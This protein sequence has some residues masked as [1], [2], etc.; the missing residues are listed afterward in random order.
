MRELWD[1]DGGQF[2][3]ARIE[4]LLGRYRGKGSIPA[5]SR[6]NPLKSRQVR[7]GEDKSSAH[8]DEWAKGVTVNYACTVK[9]RE[10]SPAARRSPIAVASA[11]ALDESVQA[12]PSSA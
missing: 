12:R 2:E 11:P 7:F 9:H 4:G 10:G 5:R 1:G 6:W 8:C 3:Q